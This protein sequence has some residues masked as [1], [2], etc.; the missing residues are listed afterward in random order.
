MNWNEYF[1]KIARTVAMKSHDPST[2]V[3]SVIVGP[4]HEIRST[5]YNDLP[6]G[7]EHLPERH[8]RPLKYTMTVHSEMNALLNALRCHIP[9]TVVHCTWLPPLPAPNA[10]YRPAATAHA[11]LYSRAYPA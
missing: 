1:M 11:P 6:R 2:K 4:D 10:P 3:G 7:I 8:E 9:V 5:G